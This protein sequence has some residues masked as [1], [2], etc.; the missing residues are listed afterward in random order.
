MQ[1]YS[2][3]VLSGGCKVNVIKLIDLTLIFGEHA[4]RVHQLFAIARVSLDSA[5]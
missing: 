1:L 2:L 3:P 4:A 5:G